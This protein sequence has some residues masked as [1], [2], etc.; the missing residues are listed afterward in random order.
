[1]QINASIASEDDL[2][3]AAFGGG[4]FAN[5]KDKAEND[6]IDSTKGSEEVKNSSLKLD[7]MGGDA[8]LLHLISIIDAGIKRRMQYKTGPR[9]NYFRKVYY[10]V[11]P[12]WALALLIYILV[13]CLEYPS[14][15]I[16][17]A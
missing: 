17:F 11:S 15:C 5:G 10:W 12:I 3:Q 7:T 4:D 1:M 16:H 8:S 6:Q 2:L 13:Q 14:F 9:A